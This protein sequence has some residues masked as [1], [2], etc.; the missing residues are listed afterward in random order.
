MWRRQNIEAPA[1]TI[2]STGAQQY[3]AKKFMLARERERE[4]ERES[5]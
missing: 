5:I 1:L 2:I 3:T 4:R